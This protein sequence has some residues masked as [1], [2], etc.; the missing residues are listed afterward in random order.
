MRQS[1]TEILFRPITERE[2][3]LTGEIVGIAITIH[4]ALGPGLLES[5]YEKCF[6]Y[7]LGKR[8]ISFLK[9]KFVKITYCSMV[10]EEGLRLDI[11]VDDLI[12]IELKAQENYHPVWEAQL[13]SYLKL[14]GKRLGYILNFHVPLMK[15]GIKRMIYN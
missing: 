4:K 3:W 1:N 10:M 13:L 15:D 11:L 7:E 14:T 6:C 12:I 9:Q 2:K 8:N 5:V